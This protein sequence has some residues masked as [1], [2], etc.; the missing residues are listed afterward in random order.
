MSTD[1]GSDHFQ[2]RIDD[3][4]RENARYRSRLRDY[5][6]AFGDV[7]PRDAARDWKT[8]REENQQLKTE[9]EEV[10]S[11]NAQLIEVFDNVFDE[12]G[13][14]RSEFAQEIIG[15]AADEQRKQ[16][17]TLTAENEQLKAKLETN[18]DEYRKQADELKAQIRLRDHRDA[19]S[20]AVGPE[21]AEGVDIDTFWNVIGYRPDADEVDMSKIAEQAASFREKK[22][23]LYKA[24]SQA[25]GGKPPGGANGASK[26][27][28]P[29]ARTL[30]SGLPGGRGAPD[31]SSGLLRVSKR[32]MAD[33]EFMRANQVAIAEASRTGTLQFVD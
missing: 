17:E 26:P 7:D 20:K 15:Q 18:P 12:E 23:F 29:E 10:K 30:T 8:Q 25:D 1:N 33:P 2:R 14:V 3:L 24:P 21:L 6:Q 4:V 9:I 31:T 28:K 16:V 11:Q 19:W 22:P 13:A 27:S 32:E 5:K